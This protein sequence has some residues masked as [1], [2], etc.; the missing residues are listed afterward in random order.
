M[1]KNDIV[2][3]VQKEEVAEFNEQFKAIIAYWFSRLALDLAHEI[4]K[5]HLTRSSLPFIKLFPQSE[6]CLASSAFN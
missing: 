1:G 5:N 3:A 2:G 6:L 4:E